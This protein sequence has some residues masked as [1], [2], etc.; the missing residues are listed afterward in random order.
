[1][2]AP[3]G[4]FNPPIN[5]AI[6]RR[7]LNDLRTGKPPHEYVGTIHVGYERLLD[8]FGHKLDEIRTYGTSDVK[9]INADYG[10]G[11]SHFLDLIRLLAFERD[12]VVSRVELHRRDVPFDKL[13]I[14]IRKIIANMATAE[15]RDG[16]FEKLLRKWARD[17]H[18]KSE[19]ELAEMVDGL[20]MPQLRY[21]LCQYVQAYNSD[22]PNQLR[23]LQLLT[24]FRGEETPARTFPSVQAYLHDLT[25]FFRLIGYTGLVIMLDEAEAI[26]SMT[27]GARGG[28]ANENIRQI[29]DN[30]QGSEGFYFVFASTP[31][32]F[33]APPG[34]VVRPGDPVTIYSYSALRRRVENLL[35]LMDPS[36]P[37]SVIVELPELTGEDFTT[38]AVKIRNIVMLA[39]GMSVAPITDPQLVSVV[40]YVRGNDPRVATLVRSVVAV[41]D[42]ARV[43]GFS[44]NAE[45]ETIVEHEREQVDR[46]ASL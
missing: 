25:H 34:G 1:M 17:Q 20:S 7:I 44:F 41:C 5:Q 13:E 24:W 12:F 9:F 22:P 30:T 18:G 40:H 2:E 23:I 19:R 39:Y 43:A 35:G 42:R 32:F 10:R 46:N 38:L 6:A 11:K 15:F 33:A 28:V 27:G 36:S 21:N 26:S 14:V 4:L 31:T 8:Y 29:I 3:L 45:F 37:D 16:G